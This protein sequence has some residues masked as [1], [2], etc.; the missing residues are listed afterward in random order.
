MTALPTFA[1]PIVWSWLKTPPVVDP[2]T[3]VKTRNLAAYFEYTWVNGDFPAS[4][5]SHYDNNVPRTT[6]VAEGFHS[7]FRVVH[8]SLRLFL[9]WLQKYQYEV[10]CRGL[11]LLA[12]RSPT[13]KTCCL[14]SSGRRPVGSQSQLQHGV[15]QLVR[16]RR[17]G[18]ITADTIMKFRA[19]TEKYYLLALEIL[20]TRLL[21]SCGTI[22][23][24]A[25]RV[26]VSNC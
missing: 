7:R 22:S 4:L 24:A 1:V 23:L 14:H 12:G 9:D 18:F 20:V 16:L 15:R 11:Q 13:V 8:P 19:A 26:I 17:Y 21:F 10:Q 6:N 2:L 5:W 3:N 25:Y